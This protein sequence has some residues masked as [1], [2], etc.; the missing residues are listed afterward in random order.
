MPDLA[1]GRGAQCP[2]C[3]DGAVALRL[4]A[5]LPLALAHTQMDALQLTPPHGFETSGFIGFFCTCFHLL[6]SLLNCV[7]HCTTLQPQ[8]SGHGVGGS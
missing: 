4:T 5:I 1:P 3:P 7:V 8:P 2:P 6:M